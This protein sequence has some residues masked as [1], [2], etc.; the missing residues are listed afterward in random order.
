VSF[1]LLLLYL[2]NVLDMLRGVLAMFDSARNIRSSLFLLQEFS[3][4]PEVC[5]ETA[6]SI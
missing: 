2:R 6:V 3:V 5:S 1:T 4:N